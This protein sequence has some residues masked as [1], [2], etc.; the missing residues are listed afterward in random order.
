MR[1][2]EEGTRRAARR[3]RELEKM[4]MKTVAMQERVSQELRH[5]TAKFVNH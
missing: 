3:E 5:C 1:K 2:L 4:R